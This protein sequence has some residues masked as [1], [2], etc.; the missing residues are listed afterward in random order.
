MS[1][2][3][4]QPGSPLRTACYQPYYCEENVW[5][6]CRHS[7]FAQRPGWALFISNESG[8]CA[9]WQQRAATGQSYVLWDYHVV[10][11]VQAALFGA[12]VWDLDCNL[13]MPVPLS[14]YLDASFPE[15]SPEHACYRP[16][17]RLVATALLQRHFSSDR[18][19][20]RNSDGSFIQ[21]PP[22]WPMPRGDEGVPHN[23][24]RFTDVTKPFI[25]ELLDL[26]ELRRRW[27]VDEPIAGWR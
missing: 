10:M 5:Q 12:E 1:A 25:G 19:H 27:R 18:R 15:L 4:T 13:G 21:P 26:P 14:D 22:C 3:P 6:L 20:M 2:P 23:L 17:F 16:R 8:R 11:V 9:M 24:H 7:Q